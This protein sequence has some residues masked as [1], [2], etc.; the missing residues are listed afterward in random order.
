MF[1]SCPWEAFV[2]QPIAF[3]EPGGQ[4]DAADCAGTLIILPARPSNVT[5]CH[6]FHLNHFRALH[7]HAAPFQLFAKRVNVQRKA[8]HIRRNQMVWDQVL[9]ILKPEQGHLRQNAAFVWNAVGQ[10]AVEGGDAVR[11]DEEQLI[12]CGPIYIAHLA[13]ADQFNAGQS[14]CC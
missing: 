12:R 1:S 14:C 9:Q 6:A 7:Q 3:F 2:R 11:C 4:W 5:A 13:A 10:N 8:V